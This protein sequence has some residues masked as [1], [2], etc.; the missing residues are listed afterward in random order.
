MQRRYDVSGAAS[1]GWRGLI[2]GDCYHHGGYGHEWDDEGRR[3]CR[4]GNHSFKVLVCVSAVQMFR[5]T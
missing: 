3:K 1:M 5:V 4:N 2:D